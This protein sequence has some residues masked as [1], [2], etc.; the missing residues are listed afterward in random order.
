MEPGVLALSVDFLVFLVLEE[1][2]GEGTG[3]LG[4]QPGGPL[5]TAAT[6]ARTQGS[7]V[8]LTLHHAPRLALV[9][10]SSEMSQPETLRTKTNDVIR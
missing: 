7:T 9:L 3:T 4:V 10:L 5:P 2:E 1:V 6:C 8:R